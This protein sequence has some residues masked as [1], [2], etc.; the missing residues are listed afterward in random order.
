[1]PHQ[2]QYRIRSFQYINHLAVFDDHVPINQADGS[3]SE[4]V[5]F[6]DHN[7]ESRIRHLKPAESQIGRPGVRAVVI[8]HETLEKD[9]R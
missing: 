3:E 2:T 1:M 8:L 5:Q 6:I 9:M 4:I 7:K